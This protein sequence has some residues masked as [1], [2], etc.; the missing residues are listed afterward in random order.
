[1]GKSQNETIALAYEVLEDFGVLTDDCYEQ[2]GSNIKIHNIKGYMDPDNR[3]YKKMKDA[4]CLNMYG[5]FVLIGCWTISKTPSSTHTFESLRTALRQYIGGEHHQRF[6][7][8]Q[9]NKKRLRPS[10]PEVKAELMPLIG[11]KATYRAYVDAIHQTTFYVEATDNEMAMS[12]AEYEV[13]DVTKRLDWALDLSTLKVEKVIKLDEAEVQQ[14]E[15]QGKFVGV[16]QP[17]K[18]FIAEHYDTHFTK[19]KAE[20]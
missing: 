18:Q 19:R 17:T 20:S 13:Q 14:D 9:T 1:M 8:W 3:N 12:L 5:E 16:V 4:N 7:A 2:F 15:K 10:A 11:P 6:V